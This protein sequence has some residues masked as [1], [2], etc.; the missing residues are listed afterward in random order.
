MKPVTWYHIITTQ[1]VHN[2]SIL[3]LT[4]VCLVLQAFTMNTL[5]RD[6]GP[7][8]HYQ[9]RMHEAMSLLSKAQK[10]HQT[11]DQPLGL[12]PRA[13]QVND[14][15]PAEGLSNMRSCDLAMFSNT[16]ALPLMDSATGIQC[17]SH[18]YCQIICDDVAA[19]S[20]HTTCK[21]LFSISWWG[22]RIARYHFQMFLSSVWLR[23]W[24]Y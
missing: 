7:A 9:F 23:S 19:A 16:A 5:R 20:T 8:I 2:V 1:H 13:L 3:A 4:V 18:C 21:V 11:C 12:R 15:K 10:G 14:R 24:P 22:D 17:W 6:R